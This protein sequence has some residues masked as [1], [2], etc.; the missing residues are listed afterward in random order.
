[1]KHIL[2]FLFFLLQVFLFS[3]NSKR[4]IDSIETIIRTSTTTDQKLLEKAG[5]ITRY[6]TSGQT[7]VAQ[8]LYEETREEAIVA[9]SQ[10]G[11][12]AAYHARG[13]LFYYQS[14]Y[15]SALHY[16][17]K[18]LEIRERIK[19][20]IGGLKSLG[21]IGSIYF[22]LEDN[23]KALYYYEETMKKEAEAHLEEGTYF[24]INNLGYVY[25]KLKMNE[26]ALAYFKKAQRI[27]EAKGSKDNLIYTYDGLSTVYKDLKNLDSALYFAEKSKDLAEALNEQSSLSYELTQIGILYMNLKKYELAKANLE[28]A[29]AM[30]ESFQDLRL[31]HS[32]YGNLA[33]IAVENDQ[34]ETA[35]VFIEKILAMPVALQKVMN[36]EDLNKLF[37]EY[38][39]KK[40]DFKKA[41][42]YIQ[43]YDVYKDSLYNLETT[44]QITEM[45]TKFETEKKEKEN[46]LLQ[47]ENSSYKVTR[48]YLAVILLFAL[49]GIVGAILAYRKIKQANMLL[50]E[51]K[52]LVEAK[53]KEILDS[54]HYAKRIQYALL[55]GD[56]VMKTNVPDHFILFK[57]KDVVSGD[58]YWAAPTSEGFVYVT[59][60]CT[61]HGVPGAFMSLLN[62]SKLSQIVNE[63]HITR[64][65]L[66]LNEARTEIIKALN[67]T[68]SEHESKD[69][70]DAIV[71]NLKLKD[72]KLEYAAANNSFYV[73]RN[74]ALLHCKAD[75]MPVGKGHDDSVSFTYNELALQSGDVIYTLTDGFPDQFGGPLGKKFKSKQLEE[76][77]LAHHLLPMEE[78]KNKLTEALR[79]WMG[80]LEQVDDI[81]I[82]GVKI[83]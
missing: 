53:Q 58:F 67:P 34:M 41:F 24:S 13:T 52:L 75:K 8:Q 5:L 73:A 26:K 17:T 37:A 35:F 65:D 54:I 49:A 82:L 42:E 55:A 76:I 81:C 29:L 28:K 50:A 3:Q 19:D 25:S 23:K 11:L 70:M 4:T 60:D 15:D 44:K 27:Y 59:G 18:A 7:A 2:T 63:N 40:K 45:Q 30:A 21:N 64:P 77:L 10:I 38:Y 1:M 78:Q 66:I 33:A 46:Q 14:L 31:Q 36:T 48:N 74:N 47:L 51:Q 69:G 71:C 20:V 80:N 39:Y 56:H 16:F 83:T 72:K 12:A 6:F 9:Q 68:G 57:P 22:M 79:Q 61:G 62:I 43:K 32:I